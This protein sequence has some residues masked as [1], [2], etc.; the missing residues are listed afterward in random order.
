MGFYYVNSLVLMHLNV[1][2][3]FLAEMD[4]QC[5]D[6]LDLAAAQGSGYGPA[7]ATA[8]LAVVNFIYLICT[9]SW[10]YAKFMGPRTVHFTTAFLVF[11]T[12]HL[13]WHQ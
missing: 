2:I 9:I 5:I 12:I 10:A 8:I 7:T 1:K 6:S 13:V 3:A 4:F 11:P